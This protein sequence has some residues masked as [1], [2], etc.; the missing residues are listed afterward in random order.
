MKKVFVFLC[1]FVLVTSICVSQKSGWGGNGRIQLRQQVSRGSTVKIQYVV[2]ESSGTGTADFRCEVTG[3]QGVIHI[4]RIVSSLWSGGQAYAE[5]TYP[6]DFGGNDEV[7]PGTLVPGTYFVQCY[8][9]IQGY[10]VNGKIAATN[11][12]FV[13]Q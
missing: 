7:K 4:A 6:Y 5:F 11:S 13:V 10:G 8:W 3:P 1:F 2:S 9:Y 12:I